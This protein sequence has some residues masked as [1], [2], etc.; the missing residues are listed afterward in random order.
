M[1]SVSFIYR[2]RFLVEHGL[3]TDIQ[4]KMKSIYFLSQIHI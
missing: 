2:M 3:N 4:Y 1:I